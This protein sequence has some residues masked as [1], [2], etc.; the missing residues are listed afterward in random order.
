MHKNYSTYN[1]D[2]VTSYDNSEWAI[3]IDDPATANLFIT[4]N[5][6]YSIID[7]TGYYKN[8]WSI[9]K[10]NSK[11]GNTYYKDFSISQINYIMEA[12]LKTS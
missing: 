6:I 1:I 10:E 11:T 4:N 9:T 8:D 3:M 7:S 2:Y 5:P 12:I